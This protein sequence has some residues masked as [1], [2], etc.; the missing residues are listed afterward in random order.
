[1]KIC[2]YCGKENSN[3]SVYCE[4]CG[5][6]LQDRNGKNDS[7]KI[8]K[9]MAMTAAGLAIIL[10][11][12]GTVLLIRKNGINKLP[13]QSVAATTDTSNIE[14]ESEPLPESEPEPEPEP[15]PELEPKSEYYVL[16][17]VLPET[18]YFYN[19]H[20]YGVYNA[21]RL[22]LDS[23]AAVVDFCREQG[24]HLA[25]IN[26]QAE[27]NYLFGIVRD[28]YSKTAFF[29]YSDE[30]EEGSWEWR[31][32]DSDYENWT[33]Y[34]QHQPDNGSGYGGDEDYAEFNYERETQSPNDGTW[35]DAPFRHNTD[36]FICEW[37]YDVEEAQR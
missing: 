8:K 12:G 30:W 4:S 24:G 27:N 13:D 7:K 2:P 11:A 25:V 10:I 36:T 21:D 37:D 1:M 14:P 17:S 32:G 31:D 6:S 3:N 29:G 20:T 33:V 18:F 15:E 34:G 19:D 5:K 28:N 35:N 23:Y 9:I 26:D 22:G 16:P